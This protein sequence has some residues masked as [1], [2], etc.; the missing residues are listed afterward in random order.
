M[1]PEVQV[2]RTRLKERLLQNCPHLTATKHG[3]EILFVVDR[4]IGDAVVR[5]C[6]ID[7]NIMCLAKAATI[8]RKHIFE[9]S[10]VCNGKLNRDEQVRSVPNV[11]LAFVSMLLEDQT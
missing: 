2:N 9:N 4:D 8:V 11:L 3:R 1:D 7:S 5:A 6:D 10:Y